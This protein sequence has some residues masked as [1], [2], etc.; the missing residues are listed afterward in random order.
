MGMTTLRAADG[1]AFGAYTAGPADAPA[2]L[3]VVQEIFGV[4]GHM[5]AVCDAFAAEGY[6]V[7]APAL[8]DRAEPGVEL[9]YGDADR[10]RGLALRGAISA[11]ATMADIEAA[12][13]SLGSR[14]LGIVGYCWAARSLGGAP[15]AQRAS[16]PPA[17]GMAAASRPRGRK[18][19]TARCSCISGRRTTAS[20]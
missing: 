20:P 17:A 14:P 6:A 10:D 16:R 19:R 1:H 11:E 2:A 18:R 3:V 8:F 7:V 15:R 13:A 12:A 5:R 9:G 4:N